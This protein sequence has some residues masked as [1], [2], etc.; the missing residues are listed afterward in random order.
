MISDVLFDASE[1]IKQYL[2]DP[3]FH[4]CYKGETERRIVG[5]LRHMRYV[6][7]LLDS[8]DDDKISGMDLNELA[9]A[10]GDK[11]ISFAQ[12]GNAD[13]AWIAATVAAHWGIRALPEGLKP[14]C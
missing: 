13:D 9:S 2:T 7:W 3:A 14:R 10:M 6:Q 12:T 8:G 5:L 1:D 11:A 4:G